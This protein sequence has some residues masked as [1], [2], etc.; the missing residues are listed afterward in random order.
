MGRMD[1]HDVLALVSHTVR[2]D[3]AFVTAPAAQGSP[4][5]TSPQLARLDDI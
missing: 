1:D 4:D 2:V 3:I 5:A